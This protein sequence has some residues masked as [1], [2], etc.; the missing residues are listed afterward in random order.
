MTL[1]KALSQATSDG[2][3]HRN[4]AQVKAPRPEQP[5]IEPLS[6]DQARKLVVTAYGIGDRYAALYV[7]A[8]HTGLREGEMLGFRWDDLDLE[9]SVPTYG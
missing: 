9:V 5:E 4:A 3:V 6:P 1:H 7:V 2:L 8:L